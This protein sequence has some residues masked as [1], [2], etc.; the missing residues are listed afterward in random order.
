MEG[1]ALPPFDSGL[2]FRYKRSE[3]FFGVLSISPITADD[4]ELFQKFWGKDGQ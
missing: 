2:F 4:L 1:E 3:D